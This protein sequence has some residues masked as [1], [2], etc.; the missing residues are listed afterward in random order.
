[1]GL[2]RGLFLEGFSLADAAPFEEWLL[3]RREH[4]WPA[5]G[6]SPDSLAAIYEGQGAYEQALAHARRRVEL[7][8][9]QED[10]QRQLMR[11][12]ARSGHRSEA[13]ARY[14]KLC[15]SLQ[16]ELG[17][18]PSAET[19]ALCEAILSGEL[20]PE[21]A[22]R[23]GPLPP[24]GTCRRHPRPFSGALDELAAL[25]AKLAEPDTRLVTLTG[26]GGSGKTRLALEVGSRLAERERQALADQSPLTFPH[27]I[28]FVPLA[29]LDSVEGLV[30][31]AGRRPATAPGRGPGTTARIPA[32]QAA[33][34][35]PGQPGA[36]AGRGRSSWP[37]SCASRP[38]SRSWPPPAS[39]CRYRAS[40]SSRLVGCP[41]R[42]TIPSAL[43]QR[44]SIWMPVWRTYPAL[45]LL[46]EGVQ[47]VR[48][49]FSPSP[50]G[51]ARHA[52]HLPPGGRPAPGSGTGRLLGRCPLP[53]RHP[54]SRRGAAWTF[55]RWTGPT[56]PS[57][58]AAC[59][60]CSTPRGGGSARQSRPCSRP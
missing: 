32:P 9:W 21:P 1:M 41:T 56:C 20:A 25:E 44:R 53:G 12:L 8:P 3:L 46:A 23:P 52:G 18:E 31:G 27:G 37:R 2:V 57:D 30:A 35:H 59:A 10:G 4:F 58:N 49:G 24:S 29:A 26:L 40:T 19:R 13:L 11:L 22:L 5:D 17:A 34:P 42:S 38:A 16:E 51:S 47:R 54:G 28:V 39:D 48:P 55:C 15:R 36:T 7:E 43:C 6:R 45:Q 33:S 14:E 50:R 60:P